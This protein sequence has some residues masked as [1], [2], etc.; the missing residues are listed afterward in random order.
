MC[1]GFFSSKKKV[2]PAQL[3]TRNK[4]QLEWRS[5]NG[6]KM[7]TTRYVTEIDEKDIEDPK[8]QT[9]VYVEGVPI[10]MVQPGM[11]QLIL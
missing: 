7:L 11:T 3:H 6:V 10:A 9:V 4:S 2:S 1:F 5:I 8:K